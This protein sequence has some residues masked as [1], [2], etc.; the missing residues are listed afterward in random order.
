MRKNIILEKSRIRSII[1]FKFYQ[2]KRYKN[3]LRSLIK[4][5]ISA[6]YVYMKEYKY[7][8]LFFSTIYIIS[9]PFRVKALNYS[10][11]LNW[12]NNWVIIEL[13]ERFHYSTG[14][15]AKWQ[16]LLFL[17]DYNTSHT[18]YVSS[19]TKLFLPATPS[20]TV[21]ILTNH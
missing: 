9:F 1:I 14:S 16:F 4:N 8:N 6:D 18:N 12:R 19:K 3:I 20:M 17:I 13:N 7:K 15:L 11:L 21:L 2:K 5:N 10:Q